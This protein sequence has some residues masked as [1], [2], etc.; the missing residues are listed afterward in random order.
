MQSR[1]AEEL[2]FVEDLIAELHELLPK[3]SAI[4]LAVQVM[5]FHLMAR[6]LSCFTRASCSMSGYS[7]PSQSILIKRSSG[8]SISDSKPPSFLSPPFPP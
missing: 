1:A 3:R 7:A 2:R 6:T 4:T 8:D 5:H